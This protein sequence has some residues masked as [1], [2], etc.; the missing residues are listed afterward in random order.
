MRKQLR[1][2][3]RHAPAD[4]DH[5]DAALRRPRLWRCQQGVAGAGQKRDRRAGIATR[6]IDAT[7]IEHE[8]MVELVQQFQLGLLRFQQFRPG[9]Q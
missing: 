3:L 1:V 6:R 4:A 2:H 5:V 9:F 8:H 7:G